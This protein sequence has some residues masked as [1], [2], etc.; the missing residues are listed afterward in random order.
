MTYCTHYIYIFLLV[1]ECEV[2]PA[3]YI[4]R[5][6]VMTVPRDPNAVMSNRIQQKEGKMRDYFS[7][8]LFLFFFYKVNS[9]FNQLDIVTCFIDVVTPICTL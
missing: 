5:V 8:H 7:F 2:V 6:R 9:F 4:D 1:H 3:V